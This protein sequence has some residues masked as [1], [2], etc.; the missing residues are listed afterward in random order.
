M[1][2]IDDCYNSETR[3]AFLTVSTAWAV[4]QPDPLAFEMALHEYFDEESHVEA[5]GRLYCLSSIES[6]AEE[7]FTHPGRTG[8]TA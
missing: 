5:D 8:V 2:F 4:K 3:V 7:Q 1:D 6:W